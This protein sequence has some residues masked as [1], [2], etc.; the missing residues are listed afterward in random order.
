MQSLIALG[1]MKEF[2]AEH[3]YYYSVKGAVVKN[4]GRGSRI[5]FPTANIKI[6]SDETPLRGVYAV[7]VKVS[8]ALYN[9]IANVGYAPTFGRNEFMVEV[10]IF[11]F[12]QDIYGKSIEILFV[13]FLREERKFDSVEQLVGQIRK[14]IEKAK[15]IL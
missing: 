8:G 7:K 9:G 1:K 13:D 3:G 12:S 4:D 11:C 2:A 5:G 6:S 14:D 15:E 10:H